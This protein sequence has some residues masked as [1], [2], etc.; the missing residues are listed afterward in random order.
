[1]SRH[2]VVAIHNRNQ[3]YGKVALFIGD[4]KKAFGAGFNISGLF[5]MR[6]GTLKLLCPL[7]IT[8]HFL[9]TLKSVATRLVEIIG[10]CFAVYH[11]LIKV[12]INLYFFKVKVKVKFRNSDGKNTNKRKSG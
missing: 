1:M 3:G 7:K 8:Y 12:R 5:R 2:F 6:V 11:K 9:R 4:G 10:L